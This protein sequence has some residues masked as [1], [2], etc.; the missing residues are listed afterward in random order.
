MA[1][2]AETSISEGKADTTV[3][4]EARSEGV[5]RKMSRRHSVARALNIENE[6][7]RELKTNVD[8]S[9][10]KLKCDD[11]RSRTRVV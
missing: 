3:S 10:S 11:S 7:R 6:M 9:V 5:R 4:T 1:A 8:Q 2:L